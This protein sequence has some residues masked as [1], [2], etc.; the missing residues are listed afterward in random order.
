VRPTDERWWELY[1]IVVR[2]GDLRGRRVLDVGC[3]TGRLAALLAERELAR[4]WGVDPTPAMLEQARARVPSGVGL[5]E[6]R[7]EELPF[8]DGWFERATMWLVVHLVDR[9]LAFAEARRVL[10]PGG[11][12]AVV[13]FDASHF[14]R[15]WLNSFF[16]SLEAI[17]R[18]RFPAR[19]ELDAELGA[20]GFGRVR[21][22]RVDQEW[23][24]T[25]E[26]ALERIAEG[27]ISTFDLLP[28]DELAS[29]RERAPRELPE[30]VD[31]PLRWLLVFADT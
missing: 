9:P 7:A 16:P 24:L 21:S 13:T 6:G 12:L 28:S 15:Y 31:A 22:V 20:A 11:R 25:R 27:H 10:A 30:R 1:E 14:D 23:S 5:R 19:G 2:E 4:V 17:D 18:A 26:E 29:G 8:R 3:G